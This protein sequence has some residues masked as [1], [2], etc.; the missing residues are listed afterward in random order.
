MW[1]CIFG[2]H[3]KKP[4]YDT[5]RAMII[6]VGVTNTELQGICRQQTDASLLRTLLSIFCLKQHDLQGYKDISYRILLLL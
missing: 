1:E 4:E 6:D 2:S 5:C 3:H